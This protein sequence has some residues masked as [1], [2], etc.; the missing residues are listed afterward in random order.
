M[1]HTCVKPS[2]GNSYESDEPEAYYCPSCDT[3]RKHLATAVDAKMG[4][5]PKKHPAPRFSPEAFKG[6]K[7]RIFF[8]AK[9]L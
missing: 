4:S 8:N 7:G 6:N 2:C 1:L 9:D 5:R 3:V